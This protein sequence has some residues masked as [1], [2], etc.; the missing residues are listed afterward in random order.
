LTVYDDLGRRV[1]DCPV[2]AV[3]RSGH[4]INYKV[5]NRE[6]R[7]YTAYVALDHPEA[8]PPTQDVIATSWVRVVHL[9]WTGEVSLTKTSESD[10]AAVLEVDITKRVVSPYNL[11]VYDNQGT[12]V[13]HR[14]GSNAVN[15]PTLTVSKSA[16]ADKA[17]VAYVSL[18]APLHGPPVED[19]TASNGVWPGKRG[20]GDTGGGNNPTIDCSQRCVGDPVNTVTGEFWETAEDLAVPA[21]IGPAAALVRTYGTSAVELDGPFGWGW[22]FNWRMGLGIALGATGETLEAASHIRVVQEN[23]SSVTF[24]RLPDGSYAGSGQSFATLELREDGTYLLTR[25]S[26][27]RFVFDS[28]GRLA[29]KEDLNGNRVT[30][31]RDSEGAITRIA[32]AHGG[33]IDVTWSGERIAKVQDQTGRQ[34]TYEYSAAGDLVKVTGLG[35]AVTKYGY[36]Q[37]HRVTSLTNSLSGVTTN[38]YDAVSRVISQTAPDGGVTQFAYP[39]GGTTITYPDGSVTKQRHLDGQLLSETVAAGTA[40]EATTY[41]T[42]TLANQLATV[43]DQLGQVTRYTYDGVGNRASE[44]DPLGRVTKT[45]YGAGGQPTRV[46]DPTGGVTVHAYDGQ[47][48]RTST[49]DA[50]GAVT[51]YA[52]GTGGRID[53]QTDPLGNVTV[54]G[55]GSAGWLTSVTGPGGAVT[56]M[57]YDSLGRLAGV[58]DPRGNA[59]GASPAVHTT[60]YEY[61]Q[62]GRVT[63]VTDPLGAVTAKRYDAAGN[64]TRETDPTGRITK[65]QYDSS[66]RLAKVTEPG[67]AA[68]A[69]TYDAVGRPK[70]VTEALGALTTYSYDAD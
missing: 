67:G 68:T 29:A 26:T 44:Q 58:T 38:A 50:R 19:V 42:Y 51:S 53:S 66:G 54:F 65:Y 31:T 15:G 43:T 13:Y 48:N 52:I 28:E 70:T 32:D 41:F 36:D 20:S 9:G 5:P 16:V 4:T 55:Y 59:S 22:T 39:S 69:Y 10:T 49:V 45:Q 63:K 27:Q 24:V 33:Y 1:W 12:R 7:T 57:S 11:T 46:V 17:Y 6:A 37:D 60:A 30:L 40:Q 34:V 23:G 21:A 62:A 64:L 25:R 61:D 2:T 47:G 35:G 8:G 3:C 14:P 18:D 56:T